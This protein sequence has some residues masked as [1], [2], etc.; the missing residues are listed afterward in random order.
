MTGASANPINNFVSWFQAISIN[1]DPESQ[2]KVLAASRKAA[3]SVFMDVGNDETGSIIM[4][5]TPDVRRVEYR[6][7]MAAVGFTPQNKGEKGS[8][9]SRQLKLNKLHS[10]KLLSK[11][12]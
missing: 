1:M 7:E 10:P 12:E 4:E 3:S 5:T 2:R 11:Q 8:T 6:A 9:E